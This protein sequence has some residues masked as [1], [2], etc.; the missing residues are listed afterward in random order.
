MGNVNS[1]SV[2][3]AI[4]VS[5]D[6]NDDDD[7]DDDDDNFSL[8]VHVLSA[9]YSGEYKCFSASLLVA[10]YA[11]VLCPSGEPT[12][13][14]FSDGED[15]VLE[16]AQGREESHRGAMVEW[17]RRKPLEEEHLILDAKNKTI[18]LPA[19]LRGRV[20]FS[21]QDSSLQLSD[22]IEGD[23]GEYWCVVLG[24]PDYIDDD[25]YI[26]SDDEDDDDDDEYPDGND[27]DGN[28]DSIWQDYK[29][30]METCISKQVTSLTP[31]EKTEDKDRGIN[32]DFTPPKKR[33]PD[34]DTPVEQ[35]ADNTIFIAVCGALAGLLIVAVI[36]AVVVVRRRRA[37]NTER[38]AV[39]G[40]G[41]KT[42]G[43]GLSEEEKLDP[44]GQGP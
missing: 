40:S 35:E 2:K 42:M 25:N 26:V 17:Y 32:T 27:D 9:N 7:N 39:M 33:D 15:V 18:I 31:K 30:F 34:T 43:T 12:E 14:Q 4:L 29:Y 21:E 36:A 3:S 41:L 28:K 19:D 11:L 38:G 10:E 23:R 24:S 20:V 37:A 6:N 13:R 5:D 16:C 1:K 8:I 22:L 44:D